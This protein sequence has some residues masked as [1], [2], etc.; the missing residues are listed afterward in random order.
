M[1]FPKAAGPDLGG[2]E[3]VCVYVCLYIHVHEQDGCIPIDVVC[4]YVCVCMHVHAQDGCISI[5]TS[6]PTDLKLVNNIINT[7]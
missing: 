1:Y 2:P 7:D 6:D 4:M 3:G 5:H